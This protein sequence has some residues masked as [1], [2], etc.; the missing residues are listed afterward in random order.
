M[1]KSDVK[2]WG[3]QRWGHQRLHAK[4]TTKV[5]ILEAASDEFESFQKK[6]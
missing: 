3:H 4:A 5:K 2:N 1:N 6:V